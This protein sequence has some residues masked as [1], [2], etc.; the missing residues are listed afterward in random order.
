MKKI[1]LL[2]LLSVVLSSCSGEKEGNKSITFKGKVK[3]EVPTDNPLIEARI[4]SYYNPDSLLAYAKAG[5]KG[6]FEIELPSEKQYYKLHVSSPGYTN[7][8]LTIP[9]IEGILGDV[10]MDIN[11][12]K[13]RVNQDYKQVF[14]VGNFS[15]WQFENLVEFKQIDENTYEA[16]LDFP[17][18]SLEY[19]IL[20]NT[21]RWAYSPIG[22]DK[23]FYDGRGS[24]FAKKYSADGKYKVTVTRDQFDTYQGKEA[25]TSDYT[26]SEPQT[27]AD[28]DKI[29]SNFGSSK[30]LELVIYYSMFVKHENDEMISFLSPE[31]IEKIAKEYGKQFEEKIKLLDELM[32]KIKNQKLK[33]ILLATK[34]IQKVGIDKAKLDEIKPLFDQM[35]T[36]PAEQPAVI[37]YIM[38][39]KEVQDNPEDFLVAIQ[40]KI[41][42]VED[43]QSASV[44]DVNF[45]NEIGQKLNHDG[46]YSEFLNE[47]YDI[48][49]A[50]KDLPNVY[51]PYIEEIKS[52][53]SV[54]MTAEAPDF[55]FK[56]F[57]GKMHK[58][59]DFRGKWVLLD[60][61]ATWCGPCREEI[62]FLVK[63]FK[64]YSNK[65]IQFI[66]V[67]HDQTIDV[68]KKYAKDK[69]MDWIQTI[70]M[71]GY[72]DAS[73]KFNIQGIPSPFLIDPDGKIIQL[74]D[75]QLRSN[76]LELTLNKYLNREGA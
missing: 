55:E 23:Y 18:D 74:N 43:K 60:F 66:S 9:N 11:L 54:K 10:S 19:Q 5:T 25:P 69:G 68:A 16:E 28:Y 71:E 37:S 24:Y 4:Y 76:N 22:A 30:F 7:I 53:L 58:L 27:F 45:L 73:E 51:R 14:L 65:E 67:S 15:N 17:S 36:I 64:K 32:P 13:A 46:S 72:C 2:L 21:D 59:S 8:E 50:N 47:R 62:P 6:Y 40:N 31:E 33:D 63:A 56:D 1:F 42:E 38:E 20:F 57:D 39:I 26:I 3:L 75:F 70:N 52:K 35:G 12:K 44:I 48:L 61:W 41:N 49:L 34:I 29:T